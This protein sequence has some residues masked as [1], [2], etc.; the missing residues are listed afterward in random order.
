M[1]SNIKA[2][3]NG[4][5]LKDVRIRSLRLLPCWKSWRVV[6]EV[7]TDNLSMKHGNQY[8][9][10]DCQGPAWESHNIWLNLT[11]ENNGLSFLQVSVSDRV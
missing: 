6:R 3:L 5:N 7:A 10:R 11:L 2:T 8:I 1:V 4:P 9:S